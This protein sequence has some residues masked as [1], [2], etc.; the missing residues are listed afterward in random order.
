M[1]YLVTLPAQVALNTILCL[2]Y[3]QAK[4]MKTTIIL[5]FLYTFFQDSLFHR[6]TTLPEADRIDFSKTKI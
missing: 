3:F 6:M 4:A 2:Y 1:S 5:N